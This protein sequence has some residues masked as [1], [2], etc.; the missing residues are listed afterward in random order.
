MVILGGTDVSDGVL[1]GQVRSGS[2]CFRYA[3]KTNN[4]LTRRSKCKLVSI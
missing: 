2:W 4:Q 1:N 3:V